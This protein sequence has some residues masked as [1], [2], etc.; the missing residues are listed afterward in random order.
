MK[1]TV[2]SGG[3]SAEREVSLVSGRAV[4]EGLQQAG[5]E[6]FRSDI[7]PRQLAGLDHPCD[8]V[9][10]ALHGSFGESGE[11]QQ[12]LEQRGLPFVGSGSKASQL[13]MDKAMAK[14]AWEAIQLPTPASEIVTSERPGRIGAP[15]VVK[16]VNSGSSLDVHIC[17]SEAD[18]LEAC[19]RVVAGHGRALVEQYIS[20]IELTVAILEDRALSPIRITTSHEFFDYT[21]KYVGDS[22]RHHFELNLPEPLVRQVKEIALRAHH[23]LGCRDLSRLDVMI[24]EQ[25]RPWLLELNTMPG[26][27]P[28]SLLPEPATHDGIPFAQLVDRLVCRAYNRAQ[29]AGPRRNV[30]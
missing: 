27:T 12:I 14:R 18:T 9:F 22:A 11:L 3:P 13:G 30:A 10:P 4:I 29:S 8:V 19:R 15:C 23:A 7:G 5:H 25:H 6:V 2:L 16:P 20:G 24:D 17:R 26:F 28:K 1:I 21:A